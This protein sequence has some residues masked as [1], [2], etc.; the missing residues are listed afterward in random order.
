MSRG[1]PKAGSYPRGQ[2]L[3]PSLLIWSRAGERVHEWRI[4]PGILNMYGAIRR[5]S[6]DE[7]L[8]LARRHAEPASPSEDPQT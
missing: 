4:K 3:Q 5:L 6:V 2:F 7:L 8:E 1:H